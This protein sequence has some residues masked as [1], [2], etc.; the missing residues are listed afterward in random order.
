MAERATAGGEETGLLPGWVVL[1]FP[2][3][4]PVSPLRLPGRDGEEGTA[5]EGQEGGPSPL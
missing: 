1:R 3:P 5:G 2:S 4:S